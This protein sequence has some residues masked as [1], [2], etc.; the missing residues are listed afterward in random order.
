M[1]VG[2]N[3]KDEQLQQVVNRTILYLDKVTKLFTFAL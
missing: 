1:M 3:L 2:K